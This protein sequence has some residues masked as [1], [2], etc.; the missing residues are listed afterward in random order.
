MY[1]CKPFRR[2]S[3]RHNILLPMLEGVLAIMIF[4]TLSGYGQEIITTFAGNGTYGFSGDS[5]PATHSS[6]RL[7]GSGGV[8][9][10]AAGNLYIADTG[11]NRIRRVDL[12]GTITT[13]AGSGL[14]GFSGD[15][16]R[17]IRAAL[18]SPAGLAVDAENNIY[19]VDNGNQRIRKVSVDG[20][21]QTVAGNGKTGYA[22]DG[23]LAILAS[24]HFS[25]GTGNCAVDKEGNLYIPDTENER[26][27]IVG[28][29]GIIRSVSYAYWPYSVSVDSTGGFYIGG[30]SRIV[31]RIDAAGINRRVAGG[32][33]ITTE[34]PDSL[35]ALSAWLNVPSGIAVDSVG[36]VYI[37]DYYLQRVRKVTPDG[38][39]ATVAGS[40]EL[41]GFPMDDVLVVDGGFSGDG[42]SASFARLNYPRG[43]AVDRSGNIYIADSGNNRIR[44]IAT[45]GPRLE[46]WTYSSLHL[47]AGNITALA[48]DP[49]AHDTVYAGTAH[50]GVFK[51][52]NAG[53][54]WSETGLTGIKIDA[55]AISRGNPTVLYA[56][57][58][59][60][61]VLRSADGGV[62]WYPEGPGIPCVNMLFVDR[63]APDNLFAGYND[64]SDLTA[65]FK[66]TDD[67]QSW[68]RI[69]V[70]TSK[71]MIVDPAN[72]DT[73]Y[74][75]NY[76]HWGMDDS[77]QLEKSI[78]GGKTWI[79]YDF[80][81][82]V[83]AHMV[84]DPTRTETLYG[85]GFGFEPF[86]STDGGKSWQ[87]Y[88]LPINA[89]EADPV[90]AG[91]LYAV[92]RGVVYRSGDGGNTWSELSAG[93]SGPVQALAVSSSNPPVVFAGTASAGVYKSAAVF[94]IDRVE[95]CIGD[96]WQVNIVNATAASS[97]GLIGGSNGLPWVWMD[98]GM[99][100]SAGGYTASG[101]FGPGSEGFHILN[102]EI[103][104]FTSNKVQVAILGCMR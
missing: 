62:T 66:S 50:D 93:L 1:D 55:L 88:S 65:L 54:D 92:A 72:P 3:D 49:I 51:S 57:T 64:D 61:G 4:G 10:D 23:G 75:L 98:W 37:A 44:K 76:G 91:T 60:S 63:N 29:D 12:S 103:G 83:I 18:N 25:Q 14:R 5:G 43:V 22:G 19:I 77:G 69:P 86:R 27:R 42:G 7:N 33:S 78:D 87:P 36:N 59:G 24:L 79:V 89:I 71:Y 101:M 35:P 67:G 47:T 8:A 13:I 46:T 94:T 80:Y 97:V 56:G 16:G 82:F 96:T 6:L 20:I 41:T 30:E 45:A 9:T 102:V 85:Y 52:T 99:T 95:Y 17:A 68:I 34:L 100:D 58:G 31:E 70:D 39:M 15:G 73:I 40:G 32:G 53:I 104:A 90:H 74:S 26:I 11:N 48:V 84:V 2:S 38:M 28:S 81:D 21:I